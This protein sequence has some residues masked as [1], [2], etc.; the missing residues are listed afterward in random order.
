[1]NEYADIA[2][3]MGAPAVATPAGDNPYHALAAGMRD[4]ADV[5]ARSALYGSLGANPD[6]AARASLLGKRYGLAV[7]TVDADF[8]AVERRAL[9]EDQDKLLRA[10]P[11]LQRWVASGD[12]AKVAADDLESLAGI[13]AAVSRYTEANGFLDRMGQR[14]RSGA[15][16]LARNADVTGAVNAG[17]ALA[18][19][20]AIDRGES[21]RDLR[22]RLYGEGYE[23]RRPRSGRDD[24][25]DQYYGASADERAEMREQYQGIFAE[26][27]QQA[28][29]RTRTAAAIPRNPAADAAIAKADKRDFAGAWDAFM[30]DPVGVVAQIGVESLPLAAPGL[31]L[32]VAVGP[33]IGT[34]VGSV[35][36]EYMNAIAAGLADEGLDLNKPETLGKLRDPEVLERVRRKAAVRAGVV[37]AFDAASGGLAGVTLLGRAASEGA[38]QGVKHTGRVAADTATG[39]PRRAALGA[40]ELGAQ[41]VAQG[42]LGA[43]GE[44]AAQ[45]AAG[46]ELQ[47]GQI[48]AEFLGEFFGAPGTVAAASLNGAVREAVAEPAADARRA[49]WAE[50][51]QAKLDALVDAAAASKLRERDPERFADLLEAQTDGTSVENV[52]IP[53]DKLVAYFQS[54]GVDPETLRAEMPDLVSQVSEALAM[55]GDIVIPAADYLSKLAPK[56]H[57]GLRE[58]IRIGQDGF[59]P[60]EAAA[61]AQATLPGAL[62]RATEE[63]VATLDAEQAGAQSAQR[64]YDDVQAQLVAAGRAPD[65]A[66]REAAVYRAFF[67]T[68]AERAGVDAWGL[69][70]RYGVQVRRELP[71]ALKSKDVGELDL[72]IERLRARRSKNDR[73]LFG[74]SLL[75]F[76][77]ENGGVIDEGGD[78]RSQDADKWRGKQVGKK[79]RL[80]RDD[81]LPLDAMVE[82]AWE[83][84]YFGPMETTE[85]PDTNTLLDAMQAELRGRPRYA[86][87]QRDERAAEVDRAVAELDRV[88]SDLGVDVQSATNGD[89]KAAL[90]TGTGAGRTAEA[91]Q[92]PAFD[93]ADA[94]A[95]PVAVLTGEEIAPAGADVKTLRQAARDFYGSTLAGTTAT[96]PT[97]GDVAFTK[98]GL[99]K[100]ISSSAN[101]LKLKL[102]PAV[103]D[104]IEKGVVVGATEN[105]KP[106]AKSDVVRYHWIEATVEVDG[107]PV[108]VRLNVEER[109]DGNLY[110]NHTLPGRE[111][112]QDE[113][114]RAGSV[115]IPGDTDGDQAPKAPPRRTDP[116]HSSRPP[117][118][119]I[120]ASSDGINLILEQTKKGGRRGRI[121]FGDGRT[122]VTLFE[123]A[124]LSTVLHETGHFFLEVLRDM[125]A[126]PT[127]PQQIRDDWAAALKWVGVGEGAAIG[128]EQHEQWARGFE[129]YLM[130]GKAPSAGLQGVFDRFRAWLVTI[131]RSI[132][133]LR[134]TVS[135]EIR[136]VFDRMLAVDDEIAAV[137]RQ[138]RYAPL[139]ESAAAAG[140]TEAEY[141]A[142][143]KAAEGARIEAGNK[144]L[145]KTMAELRRTREAWWKEERAALRTQIAEEV[146]NRQVY[147]A[148]TALQRGAYP[149]GLPLP[150]PVKLSRQALVDAYGED[151]LKLLPRGNRYVYARDGGVHPDVAAEMFGFNS[152]D[153]MVKALMNAQPIKAVVDAE[154]DQQMAALHGD[155]LSDGRLHEEAM[156]LVRNEMR[157]KALATELRALRRLGGD[158]VLRRAAERSVQVEGGKAAAAY[159]DEAVAAAERAAIQAEGGVS[160]EARDT[161]LLGEAL[162]EARGQAATGQ[163][164]AQA[165]AARQTREATA[166]DVDA[167]Q[168]AARRLIADKPVKDAT[169]FSRYMA[170]EVRASRRVEEAIAKRD[171]PAAAKAKEQQLLAHYMALEASKAEREV[172]EVLERFARLR[173]KDEKLSKGVDIDYVYAARALLTR[174]GL[175]FSRFDLPGWAE[176]LRRDDPDAADRLVMAL[177]AMLAPLPLPHRDMLLNDFR[178]LNDAVSN[179]LQVGRSVKTIEADG[180][181]VELADA[182]REMAEQVADRDTGERPGQTSQVTEAD[183]LKVGLLGWRAALTR[184]ETWARMMDGGRSDGPFTRYLVKPIMDAANAY[185]DAKRERLTQ[186]L[187]IIEPRKKDLLGGKV[188]APELGY[189]FANKGELLHAI[190]HTGN[191]SNMTK[192]LEGRKWTL[193]GWNALVGRLAGEGVL[194]KADFDTVQA[195]WD[196]NEEMK[197][198]AQKAHKRLYGY[199]FAEIT[200]RPVQ[201]P[202]G[203]YKGGY[204]PAITDRFQ[205]DEG[206]ART[207][208]DALKAQQNGSMFPSTGRGF[209]KARVENY[210]KPL[211]LN[212]MLIPS[213][214]DAVLKFTHLQPAIQQGGRV[215]INRDFRDALYGVDSTAV[216]DM[217]VPWLQRTARQTVETPSVGAAGRLADKFWRTLRKRAGLQAMVGNVLN[218]AQQITGFSSAA[219]RVSPARLGRALMAVAKG[220]VSEG[221]ARKSAF[222][223]NRMSA[224]S[225]DL[226]QRAEDI[227]TDT[228]SMD[229]LRR[230]GE[231]H[232]YF[233]QAGF[234]NFTDRVVW[235]AAY[236]QA[237]EQGK[238][239]ADAVFEADQTVRQTQG[240]FAPEDVSRFETGPAFMRLFTMFHSYFN[241]QANLLGGDA[242]S[243]LRETGWKG[244]MGRLAWLYVF[245]MMIPAVAAEAIVRG[246]KGD[247]G[248][249]E[250][251]GLLDDMLSLFFGSQARFVAGMVPVAGPVTTAA[252]NAWNSLP[253]DDRLSTSPAASTLETTVRAPVSVWKAIA[254][255][256]SAG[257]A[258]RDSLTAIGMLSGLPLGQLGKPLGYAADVAASDADPDGLGDVLSGILTGRQPKQ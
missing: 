12:N 208:G 80:L 174:H 9:L 3:A 102:F 84:G 144:L 113:G 45:R 232:G 55:G 51:D 4:E 239:D 204:M 71:E 39:L 105:T 177:D 28:A 82:K 19:F 133:S 95:A 186:L 68:M 197:G 212:L 11:R 77:A 162:A 119:R 173:K 180:R 123:R 198:E 23:R 236:E 42:A 138:A 134:V 176:R 126:D 90:E 49:Q 89:I 72:L 156:S 237:T 87:R 52:F 215:A 194:T 110:Y 209:T 255:D 137:S 94:P 5:A 130:E 192:L 225:I 220:G 30:T 235:L 127:A 92:G 79:R 96:N 171:Y 34:G 246:A 26:N 91:A 252:I 211:E 136:G 150:E 172:T 43:A 218:A 240:S 217:L 161:A 163:R 124:D 108:S 78:L 50:Q 7:E 85:R 216:S 140:M 48:A 44:A 165:A 62:D 60:R 199:A 86:E 122:I 166:V 58:D 249:D 168:A 24:L 18:L 88:L 74:P 185:R 226:M 175:D 41:I 67:R 250:D 214:I 164:R 182:V 206:Q 32:S 76:V 73:D 118:E 37:G 54:A 131:Y 141:A 69:Y 125:A 81:G 104:I 244:G 181:R 100:A 64:V 183:K 245:G 21:P 38:K 116:A 146:S 254:E 154:T 132:K 10:A 66:A 228:T 101:P 70:E 33:V 128:V 234:Q 193:A 8:D 6:R 36:T 230:F 188:A 63:A 149:D 190:A 13:E 251:D 170:A 15:V 121:Q 111:Y 189:T 167:I 106:E 169:N 27:L 1:M 53:A 139:F 147:A 229:R 243:I 120:S 40:A 59:T 14:L 219:V 159:R 109:N 57:A 238:A 155:M 65:V 196:L 17:E 227:L 97:L 184:V 191:E 22:T 256:G 112:F 117:D 231:R 221:I 103:R 99:G 46:E 143:T 222:M 187:A 98:R 56:H 253:Y 153:E 29:E 152:G 178:S 114:A 75:E 157:G 202:F 213:H 223:R 205:A 247:L 135:P 16:T 201:T 158:A 145:A 207:D 248:D 35:A 93:Q 195:L 257:K 179:L 200:A 242:A 2:R 20:D 258:V 203:E 148:I 83:A 129:A 115:T 210:T 47:P 142:Y 61:A 160:P 107:E 25:T 241:A 151:V 31:I 224:G 233:L